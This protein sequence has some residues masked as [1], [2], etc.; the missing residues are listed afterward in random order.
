[1]SNVKQ[2]QAAVERIRSLHE[3]YG[4][5]DDCGHKHAEDEPGVLYVAEIGIFVC[6]DGHFYDVCRLCCCE[7][8]S[9]GGGQT[10]T[11]ASVHNHG[12]G[13]PICETIAILDRDASV[14]DDALSYTAPAGDGQEP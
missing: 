9:G 12:V 14:W 10:E 4:I 7:Y 6:K 3:P 1:M 5:Y 13:K 2:L 11:C 8:S